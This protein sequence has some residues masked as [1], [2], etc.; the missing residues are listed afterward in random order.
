CAGS[1]RVSMVSSSPLVARN[2]RANAKSPSDIFSFEFINVSWSPFT[3]H[4][5]EKPDGRDWL[6]HLDLFGFPNG[7]LLGCGAFPNLGNSIA[8]ARCDLA[9]VRGKNSA[10]NRAPVVFEDEDFLAA[11]TIPESGRA[12]LAGGKNP[13]AVR[14]E[15]HGLN[16][17]AVPLQDMGYPP[18]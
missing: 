16:G 1:K 15:N 5:Q 10:E 3:P 2:E 4:T 7:D 11:R 17:R 18:R 12:I 9:A 14:G 8:P 6:S 13:A